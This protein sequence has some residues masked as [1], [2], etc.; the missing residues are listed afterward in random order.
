[1]TMRKRLA[2][3]LGILV[4][5]PL[6]AA[7]VL[8]S[9]AVP[10][11]DLNRLEYNVAS[12]RQ[13]IAYRILGLCQVTGVTAHAI[14]ES[15]GS[16]PP[17]VAV[18]EA[19]DGSPTVSFA[20]MVDGDTGR[21]IAKAG[22]LPGGVTVASL[23]DCSAGDASGPVLA[24]SVPVSRGN[25][26]LDRV[27]VAASVGGPWP[28]STASE[29]AVEGEVALVR[30]GVLVSPTADASVGQRMAPQ[31]VAQAQGEVDVVSA[32]GYV[33]AVQKAGAGGQPYDV[34]VVAPVSN[35]TSLLRTV[36]LVVSLAVLI[37]VLLGRWLAR[38]LT[39]DLEDLTDAVES[40][41]AG[42]L[43]R[44][45]AVRKNDE[46]GRLAAAFNHMTGELR[47]YISAL[48]SSRDEMRSNL[49]RLGEALS[50]TH[51]LDSLLPVVL[52]TARTSVAAG[53]GVV[54]LSV[55]GGPLVG[56]A[57][58]GMAAQRLRAIPSLPL[59]VGVLGRVA[60]SGSAVRGR[61]GEEPLRPAPGEPLDAQ[62][63]AVPLERAPNVL[64][65]LAVFAQGDVGFTADD[66]AALATLA[67]QAAIA[68]ENVLLHGEAKRMSVTD[69][70]TGLANFRSMSTTLNSEIERA[71]RFRRPLGL[72][73]LDLDHFKE[74]ND[75]HGHARGDDVLRELSR[76]VSGQVR[77]V[78]VFARYG[79]EEFVLILPETDRNGVAAMAR[80][81]C[82]VVRASPFRDG[83]GAELPITISIGG[84]S[85]PEDGTTGEAL[86]RAADEA[87]YRAKRAGRNGWALAE[88]GAA[89][90]SLPRPSR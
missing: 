13:A 66:E 68:V 29:L 59:G 67:G 78:D 16:V 25:G 27:W 48:E 58:Q 62:V 70:L 6:A 54:M 73:M 26:A 56:F 30:D 18:H 3:I 15:S 61:I 47:S 12:S 76:R 46:A 11:A 75:M 84:A 83:G 41:A 89:R 8:V 69:P 40:V 31:L 28:A 22:T 81:V 44:T 37:A 20:A 64:G 85:F 53:A 50:A 4:F 32:D 33:A 90:T 36:V 23:R 39:R 72:L 86:L 82:E 38:D 45:I 65:V 35:G 34:V 57:E 9:V 19:V 24:S 42:H 21:V 79:G 10:R 51:D 60:K 43:G 52:Q 14:A 1:M 17:K 80:R 71:V 74:V 2:L 55:D 49:H 88:S 87:L 63:L 77:E 7:G 5:V